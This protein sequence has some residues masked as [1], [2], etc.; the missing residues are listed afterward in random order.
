MHYLFIYPL[1]YL[2]H[3][4]NIQAT[5]EV[6]P[7]VKKALDRESPVDLTSASGF[8]D[9]MEAL[10]REKVNCSAVQYSIRRDENNI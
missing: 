1:L 3:L 6:L 10:L 7:K 5:K 4:H 2:Y 9:T 8:L